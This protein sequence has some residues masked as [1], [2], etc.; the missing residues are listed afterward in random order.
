LKIDKGT[1][2]QFL[3]DHADEADAERARRSDL[4]D[5]IDTDADADALRALGIDVQQLITKLGGLDDL[6]KKFAL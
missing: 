5:E 2:V 3:T 4:P 1:L 6:G